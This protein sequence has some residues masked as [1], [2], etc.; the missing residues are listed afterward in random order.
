MTKLHDAIATHRPQGKLAL[1]LIAGGLVAGCG[2]GGKDHWTV[3]PEGYDGIGEETFDLLE[4]QG[5][6]ILDLTTLLAQ[7]I[8]ASRFR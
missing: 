3:D 2:G 6:R 1:A 8:S 7:R 5:F 4:R